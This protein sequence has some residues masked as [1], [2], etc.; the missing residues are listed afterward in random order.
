VRT[1]RN[2]GA[3]LVMATSLLFSLLNVSPAVAADATPKQVACSDNG[4][5]GTPTI[6]PVPNVFSEVKVL[7]AVKRISS[8]R[9]RMDLRRKGIFLT[10]VFSTLNGSGLCALY[11]VNTKQKLSK[12][13]VQ[14]L[15]SMGYGRMVKFGVAQGHLLLSPSAFKV[16]SC[17]SNYLDHARADYPIHRYTARHGWTTCS[18]RS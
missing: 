6:N 18:A 2:N 17:T 3:A 15:I 8:T 4:S 16:H 7:E 11:F 5:R 1:L 9:H 10:S 12:S 14:A 13:Q